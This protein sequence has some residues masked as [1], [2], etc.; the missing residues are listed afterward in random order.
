MFRLK[1]RG[2]CH[3]VFYSLPIYAEFYPELVNL[4]SEMAKVESV[5]CTV[6]YSNYDCLPLCRVVGTRQAKAMVTSQD[7]VYTLLTGGQN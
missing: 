1:I 6:V 4:L 3:I 2:I 5:S 7:N